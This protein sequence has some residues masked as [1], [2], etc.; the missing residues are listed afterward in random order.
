MRILVFSKKIDFIRTLKETSKIV[1]SKIYIEQIECKQMA[2]V[3]LTG[4]NHLYVID[5]RLYDLLDEGYL[6]ILTKL[7]VEVVV[8]L[9]ERESIKKYMAL[10]IVDYFTFP[11]NWD[12]M[13]DCIKNAFKR[14]EVI[15]KLNSKSNAI[16][17]FVIKRRTEV[18]MIDYKEILFFEKTNKTVT[19]HTKNGSHHTN[20]S[21]KSIEAVVPDYYFRVHNSYIVNFDMISK[22][23][24]VS[25]RLYN[26]L[27]EDYE[28]IA[29]MSRY[30]AE[31]LLTNHPGKYRMGYALEA[32]RKK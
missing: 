25:S 14:Y 16:N 19:V 12:R 21:L 5:D 17:K 15:T 27:F 9:K 30:K 11:I 26:I 3:S 4:H 13:D 28:H 23:E 6:N 20:E 18:L 31:A 32:A 8:L 1:S 7:Q 29:V 2:N 10:N 24:E 22:V